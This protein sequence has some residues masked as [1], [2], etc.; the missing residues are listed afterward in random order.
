MAMHAYVIKSRENSMTHF[1]EL[2]KQTVSVK[3][4]DRRKEQN[5]INTRVTKTERN[6]LI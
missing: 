3:A 2:E 5:K 6:D 1:K 4:A